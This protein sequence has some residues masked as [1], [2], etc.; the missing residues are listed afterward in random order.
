MPQSPPSITNDKKL[1]YPVTNSKI[2][3]ANNVRRIWGVEW[4]QRDIVYK[5]SNGRIFRDSAANGGPY[6]TQS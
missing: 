2:D 3:Y 5:F 4:A 6:G 1:V